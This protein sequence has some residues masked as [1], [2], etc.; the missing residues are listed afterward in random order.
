VRCVGVDY[1]SVGGMNSGAATHHALLE[2]GIWII[3]GLDLGRVT[4]G[5]YELFCLPVRLVGADGAPARALLRPSER[6]NG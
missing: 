5:D 3:E 2:R 6:S 4:A 1:L